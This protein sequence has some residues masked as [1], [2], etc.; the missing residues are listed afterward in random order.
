MALIIAQV[1]ALVLL[2]LSAAFDTVD[3]NILL[4]RLEQ[5]FGLKGM[6]LK[7]VQSY[8][9]N[10]T[11]YVS[12]HEAISEVV[13]LLFGVPQGSVLGPLLF[14]LCTHPLGNIARRHGIGIH[15]YADDTQLYVTM[16]VL[17]ETS[18]TAS[19]AKM[20]DCITDI[21]SWMNCNLLKLNDSKTDVLVLAS[22]HYITTITDMT[23]RVGDTSIP[24]SQFVRNLGV[25]FDQTMNMKKHIT[26][27]CQSSFIQLRNIRSLKPFLT[28]DALMTVAH[29]FISSRIDYCNS[30]LIG[31]SDASVGQLQRIQNC[32]ARLI[33][34]TRKYDHIR[35]VLRRLHW[36]PVKQRIIFKILLL[37][38]KAVHGLAPSYICELVEIKQP[39]RELRSSS[40]CLL[41]IPKTRLKTYGDASFSVYGPTQWNNLPEHIRSSTTVSKFKTLLKTYLFNTAYSDM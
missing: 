1:V 12:I 13:C 25:M 21:R 32:T 15:M 28:P 2:D 9:S 3:H 30:L 16:D 23:I 34:N 6:V 27:V 26:S 31:I 4:K 10:R 39:T 36:L 38:F 8:L 20:T 37:T 5:V 41:K 22:P 35:P 40:Q 17:N 24:S 14:V 11:Q 7:W 19:L 33:T 29:A 18:K